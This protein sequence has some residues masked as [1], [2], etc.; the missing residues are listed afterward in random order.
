L[1]SEGFG[2]SQNTSEAAALTAKL[3]G[4]SARGTRGEKTFKLPSPSTPEEIA[5]GDNYRPYAR[6][7]YWSA[8]ILIGE[9][10]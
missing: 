8:F 2:R 7:H 10:E 5:A 1:A 9:A 3:T 6:P 4:R